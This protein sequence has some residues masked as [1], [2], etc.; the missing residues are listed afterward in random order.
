V[1]LL[2]AEEAERELLVRELKSV[3]YRYLAPLF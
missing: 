2:Q 3:L 1:H